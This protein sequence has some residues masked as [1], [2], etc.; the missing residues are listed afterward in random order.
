MKKIK[1]ILSTTLLSTFFIFF[2]S[3]DNTLAALAKEEALAKKQGIMLFNQYKIAEPEL[4]I[5]A[6]A[7]DR[8]SQFYLAEYI[9]KQNQY[10]TPEA[11]KWYEAS[12]IQGD[13]Y[14]MFRLATSKSDLCNVI[15]QC[16]PGLNTPNDWMK[17]LLKTT[18]PLIQKG[19]GEAMAVMYSIKGELDWLKRSADAGYAPAQRLL[20]NRYKE[21]E[22]FF[23][24]PWARSQ[25]TEDLLKQAAEGG[26][27]KAMMEYFGILRGEGDL[28]GARYWLEQAAKT[29]YESGVYAYGYFLAVEP[30]TLGFKT[31]LVKGHALISLLKELDGGGGVQKFVDD[32][33]PKIE[34]KMTSLQITE[35]ERKSAEWKATH[36][37]LSF[38]P[39]KL[40]F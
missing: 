38:F 34:S 12:A 2:A 30:D 25:A 14:A 24:F 17:L 3:I 35:A 16:P 11:K 8:E 6:G 32:T 9:R 37:P 22:G 21:G 19:D 33:L 31:D 15:K 20:A 7:G 29:G 28:A 40:G 4:R 1:S 13:Y 36:P 18:E 10:I 5:A 26:N 23:I 39:P 27:P